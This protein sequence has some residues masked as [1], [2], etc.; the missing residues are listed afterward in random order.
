MN[1]YLILSDS[2]DH[3]IPF[4]IKSYASTSGRLDVLARTLITYTEIVEKMP[5]IYPYAFI[6]TNIN[7]KTSILE[8]KVPLPPSLRNEHRLMMAMNLDIQRKSEFILK[9]ISARL[10]EDI[11]KNAVVLNL[12]EKG[13]AV[14]TV[15]QDII[16]NI[17]KTNK[18]AIVLGGHKDI[19]TYVRMLLRRYKTYNISVGKLSY[20]SSQTLTIILFSIFK[21]LLNKRF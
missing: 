4:N 8:V 19:H 15:I 11:M 7:T 13:K 16:K 14:S 17:M 5:N 2:G 10:L 12:T 21:A 6:V 18:L 9:D 1:I 3:K 20:F